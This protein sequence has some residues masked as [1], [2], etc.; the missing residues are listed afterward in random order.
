ML[1]TAALLLAAPACGGGSDDAASTTTDD[2]TTSTSTEA[3]PTTD[4]TTTTAAPPTTSPPPDPCAATTIRDQLAASGAA[5][6]QV[7]E[8]V[9]GLCVD[10][11]ALV[12]ADPGELGDTWV[13]AQL[14]DGSWVVFTGFPSRLC[15]DEAAAQGVAP[16]ILDRGPFGPCV[17]TDSAVGAPPCDLPTAG[18]AFAQPFCDGEWGLLAWGSA[19]NVG[20]S[21]FR[22]EGGAWVELAG[23]SPGGGGR[24]ID[25]LRGSGAPAET[26]RILCETLAGVHSDVASQC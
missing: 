1:A 12:D 13:L 24:L 14:V 22:Y 9:D 18:F 10:G 7:V 3:P 20:W 15:V 25:V 6:G 17:Q 2:A 16:A 26:A 4:A 11:W 19:S 23:A 8:V 5:V 21:V